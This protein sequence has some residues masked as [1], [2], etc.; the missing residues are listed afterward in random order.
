MNEL[1][2]LMNISKDIHEELT[3]CLNW[4]S[5]SQQFQGPDCEDNFFDNTDVAKWLHFEASAWLQDTSCD[6]SSKY[7]YEY[8][9]EN[10]T[11]IKNH[12]SNQEYSNRLLVI[13]DKL[14]LFT[15]NSETDI[16]RAIS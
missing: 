5:E 13:Y 14:I 3:D 7:G 1:S 16:K 6:I 11:N 12:I 2:Q 9:L 4:I 8:F 15:T 10:K